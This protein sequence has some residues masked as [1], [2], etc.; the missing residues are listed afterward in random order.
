MNSPE[1]YG[2]DC[3]AKMQ[4]LMNNYVTKDFSWKIIQLQWDQLFFP[5]KI[6]CLNH[7][8][9]A[10]FNQQ[11]PHTLRHASETP[12]MEQRL[13]DFVSTHAQ[14][15]VIFLPSSL[16]IFN[17]KGESSQVSQF[18]HVIAQ[19]VETPSKAQR[20]SGFV[21]THVQLLVILLPSGF[22]TLNLREVSVQE[23]SVR[24]LEAQVSGMPSG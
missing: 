11:D 3:L 10:D 20:L 22:V 2:E 14:V 6:T 9:Q 15:L 17:F 12:E 4:N 8:V 5:G 23:A 19:V 18:P 13:S 7:I 24:L 16:T 21:A 1:K